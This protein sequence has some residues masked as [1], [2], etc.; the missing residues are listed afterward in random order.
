MRG[1]IGQGDGWSDGG[2]GVD[3]TRLISYIFGRGAGG[4]G[5]GG[6]DR[7]PDLETFMGPFG[8]RNWY[9]SDVCYCVGRYV[10]FTV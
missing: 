3:G 9:R 10:Y 4:G 5:G 1:F 7:L 2:V 6:G 8:K